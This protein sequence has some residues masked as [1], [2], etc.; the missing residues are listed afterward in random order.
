MGNSGQK[1]WRGCERASW[2]KIVFPEDLSASPETEI[3]CDFHP[4]SRKK[5][6]S[7]PSLNHAHKVEHGCLSS[8][9][10]DS[11]DDISKKKNIL[12]QNGV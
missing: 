5:D 6:S 10:H 8:I 1:R 7:D 12:K 11:K 2:E 4:T 3:S 9:I